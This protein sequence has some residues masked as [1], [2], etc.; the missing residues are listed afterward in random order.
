[1]RRYYLQRK[2]EEPID[3]T[4]MGTFSV[5]RLGNIRI[6]DDPYISSIHFLISLPTTDHDSAILIDGNGVRPSRNGTV[7]N[8]VTL[9]LSS[10]KELDKAALLKH[11]DVI[12][13][14][15]TIFKFLVFEAEHKDILNHKETLS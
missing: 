3:I 1:M 15:K 4:N 5:G 11:G 9:N 7:I 14:G 13:V 2:G 8:G 10:T 12:S 6:E